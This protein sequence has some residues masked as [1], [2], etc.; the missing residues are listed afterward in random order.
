MSINWIGGILSVVVLGLILLTGLILQNSVRL[1]ITG[2]RAV[3]V[4]VGTDTSSRFSV[5]STEAPL[6]ALTVEFSI[7]TGDR[8]RVSGRSYS[9]SLSVPLGDVVTVAYNPSSP[10]NA[11][12]LL[13]SEF[14]LVPAGFILGFI[15]VIILMWMAGI[16][17]SGDSKMDDPFRLLPSVISHFHRNPAKLKTSGV[18]AVATVI[19]A[20]Q[21][22]HLLHYRIDKDTALPAAK[23]HDFISLEI[24]LP[25]WNQSQTEAEIRKGDQFR[26]YL[27]PLKPDKNYYIDFS[28][29]LG[30]DPLVQ[31]L[32]EEDESDGVDEEEMVGKLKDLI[33]VSSPYLP[34]ESIGDIELLMMKDELS[35][36]F[37]KLMTGIMD[38]P[39]PLPIPIQSLDWNDCSELGAKLGLNEKSE[40]DPGFWEKFRIF[41]ASGINPTWKK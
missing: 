5:T 24:T 10:R 19:E 28:N 25:D 3:G 17:M 31:S 22:S 38:L 15:G 37:E 35:L 34:L 18:H 6:K 20:N 26:V 13:W 30:N 4:V 16:V 1:L 14:P 27:D 41:R 8:I 12:L 7:S 32:D 9:S 36:A 39:K 33:A 11:Q 21:E 23:S 29:K 2:N 40:D